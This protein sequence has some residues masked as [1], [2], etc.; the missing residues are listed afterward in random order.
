[1]K[2]ENSI[3]GAFDWGHAL[4]LAM[5]L[6]AGYSAGYWQDQYEKADC[7]ASRLASETARLHPSNATYILYPKQL[8]VCAQTAWGAE[9]GY[10]CFNATENLTMV[11]EVYG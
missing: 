6:V 8:E 11:L 7:S 4:L 3:W 5:F 1:M 9:Y 2:K 10:N